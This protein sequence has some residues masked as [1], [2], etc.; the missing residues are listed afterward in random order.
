M[1][2]NPQPLYRFVK[3]SD[4]LPEPNRLLALR[5]TNPDGYK[6]MLSGQYKDAGYFN[7]PLGRYEVDKIEWLEELQSPINDAELEAE[8]K[9]ILNRYISFYNTDVNDISK[10][11]LNG[12]EVKL[13]VQ[14]MLEFAIRCCQIHVSRNEYRTQQTINEDLSFVLQETKTVESAEGVLALHFGSDLYKLS[15]AGYFSHI[16]S[17]MEEY[18]KQFQPQQQVDLNEVRKHAWEACVEHLRYIQRKQAGF[19]Y[20]EEPN[21]ETYL[22]SFNNK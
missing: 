9:D 21:K 3:A 7:C 15:D 14:A 18:S 8:A 17:A 22:S 10:F 4:T 16:I 6:K 13:F 2:N 20:L 1:N 11:R 5:F 19:D 12:K